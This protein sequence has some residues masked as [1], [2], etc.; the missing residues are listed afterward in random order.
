MNTLPYNNND[1]KSLT[2]ECRHLNIFPI[3]FPNYLYSK[4][5][6]PILKL[7]KRLVDEGYEYLLLMNIEEIKRLI[8]TIPSGVRTYVEFDELTDFHDEEYLKRISLYHLV[9]IVE[10]TYNSFE[11][12]IKSDKNNNSV[13][14]TYPELKNKLDKDGLLII[15][16]DFTLHDN[17]IIYKNHVLHYHQFLRRGYTGNPNFDF[18]GKFIAYY[19]KT[20]QTNNFRIGI[21]MQRVMPKE[22]LENLFERDAWFGTDFDASKLDDPYTIGLTVKK[23][24]K[25]L[26]H[27]NLDRTEFLWA[28]KDSIKTFEVEEISNT[29]YKFDR[30]N[31]NKYIHSERDIFNHKLQHFDGAVKIYYSHEY[32]K[33]FNTKLPNEFKAPLKIKLFRIDGDINIDKWIDLTNY[34]FKGNEMILEYFN[35]D[36]FQ[37]IFK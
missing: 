26:G 34:F 6:N 4:S 25:P 1:L 33:R 28:Y 8:M 23:R 17:G 29:E 37:R 36:M 27:N 13:L 35:P 10:M 20:N 19:Y 16:N 30:F 2:K 24:I 22:Y 7:L 14:K 21:D 3:Y 15:D 18:I 9:H 31:I 5:N 12:I 11:E 32:N